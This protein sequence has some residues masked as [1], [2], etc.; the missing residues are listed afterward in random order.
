MDKDLFVKIMEF[1]SNSIQGQEEFFDKTYNFFSNSIIN[2]IAKMTTYEKLLDI[3]ETSICGTD[4][5]DVLRYV[6]YEC[7]CDSSKTKFYDDEKH[8]I[9]ELKNF[10]DLYNFMVKLREKAN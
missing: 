2:Q 6:V 4:T 7:N 10:E 8:N 3:I 1:I 9:I 5:F